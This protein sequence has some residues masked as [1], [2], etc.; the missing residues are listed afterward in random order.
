MNER[1]SARARVLGQVLVE[2]ADYPK[3]KEF[4]QYGEKQTPGLTFKK[5][6]GSNKQNRIFLSFYFMYNNIPLQ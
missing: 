5:S 2:K 3:K 6:R 4:S 1:E